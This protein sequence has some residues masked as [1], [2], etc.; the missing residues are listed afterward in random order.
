MLSAVQAAMAT[1]EVNAAMGVVC[2]TPTA[3]SS[4]TL[5]GVIMALKQQRYLTRDALIHF[6]FTA[7]GIGL[8]IANQAG[9]AGTTGAARR[10]SGQPVQWLQR[11]LKPRRERQPKVHK[12]LPLR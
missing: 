11:Q 9:I 7:G 12:P 2:A 6:L 3:G 1:N 10:K 8:I 4:G 5:P